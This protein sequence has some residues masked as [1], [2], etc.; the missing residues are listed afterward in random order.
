MGH[1]WNPRG[2]VVLYTAGMRN[3][4]KRLT[5]A[6]LLLMGGLAAGLGAGLG[7]CGAFAD[8]K[9]G[10]KSILEFSQ[11]P[12][13]EE[14]AAWAIDPYD[15]NNRYRGTQILAGQPFAS[16]SLYIKLFE[17][18]AGDEDP[19]VRAAAIR[20][21]ANHGGPEHAPRL[22]ALLTDADLNV[23]IEAARGLQRLHN[24]AAIDPLLERLDSD[25]EPEP[26]V[27]AAAASA[28]GQYAQRRVVERLIT[29]LSDENL[30]VNVSTQGALRTLTGQDLGIDRGAWAEWYRS[31]RNVFAARSVY[32]YPIFRR[33][34]FWYEYIPFVPPPPNEVTSPPAGMDR[35]TVQ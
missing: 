20:G 23:R 16:E 31:D 5:P 29:S 25:K 17:T 15:A 3:D 12:T 9:P 4:S 6:G 21:L 10:A 35:G 1:T 11:G 14:A 13:V 18:N 30:A 28:L 24:P 7:G 27:R 32:E 33:G 19:G 34:K 26:S 8:L 2:R 22:I